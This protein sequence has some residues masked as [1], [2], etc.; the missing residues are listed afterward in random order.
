MTIIDKDS[1]IKEIMDSLE[2]VAKVIKS[3]CGKEAF[4]IDKEDI[5]KVLAEEMLFF[6]ID[7]GKQS[8]E[9]GNTISLSDLRKKLVV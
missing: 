4:L 5:E 9:S 2:K 6:E 8:I 7:K 3:D 1:S